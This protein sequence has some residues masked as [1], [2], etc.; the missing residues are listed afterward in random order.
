MS[1]SLKTNKADLRPLKQHKKFQTENRTN[2]G[3]P[4][5]VNESKHQQLPTADQDNRTFLYTTE[6]IFN[7]QSPG[8]ALSDEKRADFGHMIM[9]LKEASSAL[10]RDIR[11]RIP[12]KTPCRT[13]RVLEDKPAIDEES[14]IKATKHARSF[15]RLFEQVPTDVLQWWPE[16]CALEVS[17]LRG[18]DILHRNP[19]LLDSGVLS[20]DILIIFRELRE[21]HLE[22]SARSVDILCELEL[23]EAEAT[24]L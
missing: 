11:N 16:L 19:H 14:V 3:R 15:K 18:K 22:S 24:S 9:S 21:I 12:P 23:E 5:I 17:A 20:Q 4:D 10:P 2:M 7:R 6:D 13:K 8:Y 1:N